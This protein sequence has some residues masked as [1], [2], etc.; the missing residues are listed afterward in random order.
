ME[1]YAFVLL[2][3]L[4]GAIVVNKDPRV[5]KGYYILVIFFLFF[6]STFR[7]SNMGRDYGGYISIFHNMVWRGGHY[8]KEEGFNT[9]SRIV[10]SISESHVFFS[11]CINLMLFIPL[12]VFFKRYIKEED[13]LIA[14]YIFAAN[15]YLYLQTTFNMLRQ[16]CATGIILVALMLFYNRRL[17]N[18]VLFV[19]LVLL[20]RTFHRSS[21]IVL[22][23]IPITLIKWSKRRWI[24][25][26]TVSLLI[27][28]F[29]SSG[30][31]GRF[32][33]L[34]GYESY[35]TFEASFLNNPLYIVL[36]YLYV[37]ILSCSYDEFIKNESDRIYID[38]YMFSLCL[39]LFAVKNDAVY[40]IRILFLY[41]SFP[42]LPVIFRNLTTEPFFEMILRKKMEGR[43]LMVSF[44]YLYYFFFFIGYILLLAF[45]NNTYYVPFKFVSF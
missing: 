36:M 29:F 1:I 7:S 6:I 30:V 14:L 11:L 26:A 2:L 40:R 5:R 22:A 18:Y 25:A 45:N 33:T 44:H 13:R 42:A 3:P 17:Y 37:I 34:I 16:C 31:I 35:S 10:G 21:I 15:P 12:L 8:F 9:F 28:F 23:I 24:I 32:A 43:S 38:I 27:S 20:A 4:L 39:L 41:M 19:L